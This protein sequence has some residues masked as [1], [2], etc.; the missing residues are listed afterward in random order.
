MN[1][2][3]KTSIMDPFGLREKFSDQ[4]EHSFHLRKKNQNSFCDIL[5]LVD[6]GRGLSNMVCTFLILAAV[7]YTVKMQFY[8]KKTEVKL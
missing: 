6:M 3:L 1:F 8:H 7:F 5:D 2:S 4:E